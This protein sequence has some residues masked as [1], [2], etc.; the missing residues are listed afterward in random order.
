MVNL[1]SF[2]AATPLARSDVV[3]RH[4]R[5]AVHIQPF[6]MDMR[7]IGTTTAALQ[8]IRLELHTAA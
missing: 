8:A 2:S 5:Y 7:Q 6:D 3:L 4:R 1:G